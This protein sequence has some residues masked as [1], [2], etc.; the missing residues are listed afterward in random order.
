MK[1]LRLCAKH[2][3][4][5]LIVAAA[6]VALLHPYNATANDD[7]PGFQGASYLTTVTDS[8]GNF[9]TRTVIT[10]HADHTMSTVDADSGGPT[11]YFTGEFG[12][13][14]PDGKGGAV[15]RTID[16]DLYPHY[17]YPNGDV[18]RID[19]TISFQNDGP[20]IV[21]IVG[22][23]TITIFPLQGNPFDGGGTNAGTFNFTGQ[24][25]TP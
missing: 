12:S 5:T 21:G 18:A 13:W 8:N 17:L 1:H 2:G 7:N 9:R 10:L 15:G 24:L 11:Y 4:L 3:A 16:F 23:H 25:I 22:T 6:C 19:Y 14:R 20:R